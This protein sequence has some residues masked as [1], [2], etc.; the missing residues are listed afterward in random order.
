MSDGVA[1]LCRLQPHSATHPLA[2]RLGSRLQPA[3]SEHHQ[4]PACSA[5]APPPLAPPPPLS[6]QAG[7]SLGSSSSPRR[8]LGSPWGPA[9]LHPPPPSPSIQA[10]RLGRPARR[11]CLARAGHLGRAQPQPLARP[12]AASL[13]SRRP[14]PL[15]AACLGSRAHQALVLLNPSQPL[16]QAASLA[17]PAH[18]ACLVPKTPSTSRLKGHSS[19][20]KPSSSLCLHNLWVCS[21]ALLSSSRMTCLCACSPCL[22]DRCSARC[23]TTLCLVQ[24]VHTERSSSQLEAILYSSAQRAE[25]D[26][27]QVWQPALMA[28]CQ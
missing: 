8:A 14:S 11:P 5:P 4:R 3:S 21:T 6:G 2:L 26:L 23:L 22:C 27:L 20:S 19:S 7:P 13:G 1:M 16:E 28:C 17:R 9:V 18:P 12:A 24:V 25:L 15:A 10:A